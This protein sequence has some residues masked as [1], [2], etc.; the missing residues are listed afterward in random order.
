MNKINVIVLVLITISFLGIGYLDLHYK[1]DLQNEINTI[2]ND[3][4]IL[5]YNLNFIITFKEQEIY[6]INKEL[7]ITTKELKTIINENSN[8]KSELRDSKI[9]YYNTY[10][11]NTKPTYEEVMKFIKNDETDK[12]KYIIHDFDCSHFSSIVVKNALSSNI[13][14]CVVDIDF[15]AN[16]DG[17]ID[18]GHMI[19]AFNT[20]DKGII[21]IEPQNDKIVDLH[22]GMNYWCSINNIKSCSNVYVI[23]YNSCF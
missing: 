5:D 3:L 12:E 14:A 19:V 23:N 16:S 13:F 22:I 1:E 8:L 20:I 10:E 11:L 7:E 9:Q 4:K 18:S 2:Q 21:Y 15:D 6:N 17:E